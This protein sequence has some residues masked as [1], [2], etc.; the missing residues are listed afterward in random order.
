MHSSSDKIDFNFI[1]RK[2][3]GGNF[4]HHSFQALSV[5]SLKG[6]LLLTEQVLRMIADINFPKQKAINYLYLLYL[7][8]IKLERSNT[9]RGTISDTKN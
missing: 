8:G 1:K 5:Q 3:G 9:A 2:K 6:Q 7:S 4:C